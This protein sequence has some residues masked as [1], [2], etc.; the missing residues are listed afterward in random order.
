LEGVCEEVKRRQ[1][2][3]GDLKEQ[4][5]EKWPLIIAHAYTQRVN[6]HSTEL[7]RAPHY[8]QPV[9]HY[10]KGKFFAYFTYSF[11]VS[12]VEIDVLTGEFVVLRTDLLYDAGISLNPA[13]DIGQIEGGF[14]QGLGFVTTEE[15]LYDHDGRLTTDNIWSY[16]PPCSKTIPLD[17]RV[18]LV[19]RDLASCIKQE[20]AG[21]MAVRA[22]KSTAEPC[23]SLGNS[24]YFAIKQAI[25]A[26]RK[27]QTG[28]DEWLTLP[29]PL[30]CQRIQQACAVSADKLTLT[31]GQ[32]TAQTV[33]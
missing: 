14:V 5:R 27:E 28:K 24:V 4:W 25:R 21:L 13:L 19:P 18:S 33:S 31:G 23:L 22:S 7:Y 30:T 17:M 32:K 8:D 11:T 6:L 20:Q 3:L 10:D 29:V 1:P 16:K 26:A 9:D 2:E 15:A 12:E